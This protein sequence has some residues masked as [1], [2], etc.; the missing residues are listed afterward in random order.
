MMLLSV[1]RQAVRNPA[2]ATPTLVIGAGAVGEHLVE[3]LSSDP[4]YGLRPGRV[5]GLKPAPLIGSFKHAGRS[6]A[7]WYQGPSRHDRDD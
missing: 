3:R 1:R 2:L 4:R 5:P 6:A 7:R